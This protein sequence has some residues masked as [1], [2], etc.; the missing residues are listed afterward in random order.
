[1]AGA[2][3]HRGSVVGM[4]ACVSPYA[5]A[6][7]EARLWTAGVGAA[8][9]ADRRDGAE[10]GRY[11]GKYLGKS[12]DA[13]GGTAILQSLSVAAIVLHPRGP[14]AVVSSAA[15]PVECDSGFPD[16]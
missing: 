3:L 5:G 10:S 1:M 7:A 11:R 8:G 15:V 13:V 16:G 14:R 9:D 4:F 2:A 12:F 6:Y